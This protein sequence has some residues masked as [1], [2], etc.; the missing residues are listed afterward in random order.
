MRRR[1]RRGLLRD[2]VADEA[3]GK[4]DRDGEC[5]DHGACLPPSLRGLLCHTR[6]EGLQP[7]IRVLALVGLRDDKPADQVRREHSG[8][9]RVSRLAGASTSHPAPEFLSDCA[10]RADVL[11]YGFAEFNERAFALA[12]CVVV[13]LER[14]I[15]GR[16][17]AELADRSSI[18]VPTLKRMEAS[19]GP[20]AGLANNVA[21]V[22]QALESAG[23]EFIAENGGGP[24]VR[25]RKF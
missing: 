20:A 1:R 4:R 14:E 11:I 25:L 13:P 6:V 21:A 19:S 24:G 18:S 5:L 8:W 15:G 2:G 9:A 12:R 7:P 10:H 22:R 16:G 23:I 17:Q 3:Y